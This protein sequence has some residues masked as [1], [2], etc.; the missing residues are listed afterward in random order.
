MR[1]NIMGK[2]MLGIGVILFLM[3]GV[4]LFFVRNLITINSINTDM[5][6][7][8]AVVYADSE[9]ILAYYNAAVSYL[10][11]YALTGDLN[12]LDKF[13][14]T[15]NSADDEL[16]KILPEMEGVEEKKLYDDLQR[17]SAYLQ[18]QCQQVIPLVQDR[19]AA[20]GAARAAA[21]KQLLDYLDSHGGAVTDVTDAGEELAKY[22]SKVLEVEHDNVQAKVANIIKVSIV[23]AILMLILGLFISFIVAKMITN[24]IRLVDAEAAK[25]AAGDLT[26]EKITVRAKDEAGR[27]AESFNI[28]LETLKE[29]VQQL[30]E[31][32]Q[33]VAAYAAELSASSENIT[34]AVSE[35]AS[36]ITQVASSVDLVTANAQNI[37]DTSAHAAGLAREGSEGLHSVVRQMSDIQQMSSHSIEIVQGLSGAAGKITQIVELIN[38]IADQTNLLALNAA[39][40][41][42]RAGDHGRGFAV[43]ADEVKKLAEQSASAAK[44]IKT[45]IYNVQQESQKAVQGAEQNAALVEAGSHVIQDIKV[46][47]EKIISSVQGLAE[48]IR[49]VAFSASEMSAAVQ[50]IAATAEEETA[51]MEEVASTTQVMAGMAGDLEA[52]ASRFKI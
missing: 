8:N 43:V 15:I 3:L 48:E 22:E 27:L 41:A 14:N 47:F 40:E 21:E 36:T 37:A 5:V 12:H 51:T 33:D 9:R 18:Q 24:P 20:S 6:D 49:Q 7:H 10:R 52:L 45:L 42:A 25:I 34:A 29:V 23:V 31:K 35:T 26:G 32:S 13:K 38:Q 1:L 50:D 46:M 19:E 28:M 11:E 17:K 39:I 44:E 30:Q 16:Q 4:C 2:I